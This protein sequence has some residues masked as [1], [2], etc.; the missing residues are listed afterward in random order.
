VHCL[1][2]VIVELAKSSTL[3]SKFFA[4]IQGL[5]VLIGASAKHLHFFTIAQK[6]ELRRLVIDQDGEKELE[7]ETDAEN[8]N[9]DVESEPIEDE[10]QRKRRHTDHTLNCEKPKQMLKLKQIGE[11]R[12]SC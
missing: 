5:A 9:D 7:Y 6:D 2:L 8:V 12:W 11:I 1:N 3:V 4:T 10:P